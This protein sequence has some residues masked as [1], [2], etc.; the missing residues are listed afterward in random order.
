MRLV[1]LFLLSLNFLPA[2]SQADGQRA[3]RVLFYNVENLF[4]PKNDPSTNDDEFTPDGP[5]RW[6]WRRYRQKLQHV[7]KAITA[8][9]QWETPALVGLCEVEGDSVVADLVG[10]T[11]LRGQG[12]LY[13][14]GQ[15]RDPRGTHVA[16]LYQPH[17]FKP[18]HHESIP[19]RF[20]GRRHKATRDLL[21]VAGL[22]ATGDTL[23][24]LVA[25]FPSRYGGEKE[26]ERDRTDAARTLRTAIDSIAARRADPSFL[27]MG[28]LNDEPDDKSP[29]LLL[30]A[31]GLRNLYEGIPRRDMP[32]SHKYQGQWSRLDQ[33]IVSERLLSPQAPIRLRPGSFRVFDA[34]FLLT[35]D[36]TW[37]GLRPFRAYYGY[38]Y[39]GGFSDHLP[40]LADFLL[41]E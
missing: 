2:A 13:I 39:E 6:T 38:R 34:D 33:M 27:I 25:H 32:G 5:R 15:T 17:R 41:G 3:F 14:I 26:S 18:L 29:R 9:G 31:G 19:V 10:R 12:Y 21:H 35:E 4:S 11:A 20:T 28:D 24:V 40:I 7:A 30:A 1:L 16:L 36:K 37:L 8:A 23:D 22:V